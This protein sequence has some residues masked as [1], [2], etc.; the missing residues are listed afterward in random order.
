MKIENVEIGRKVIYKSFGKTEFGVITSFNE[1]YVFS[2][3]KQISEADFH[4]VGTYFSLYWSGFL[5]PEAD[6]HF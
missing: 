2:L 4:F 3:K 1:K 5:L 6:F